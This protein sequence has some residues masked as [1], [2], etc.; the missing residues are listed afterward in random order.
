MHVLEIPK[1]TRYFR[2]HHSVCAAG[3]LSRSQT[4]HCNGVLLRRQRRKAAQ[5]PSLIA[6][7]G[8]PIAS[9]E[10]C[11]TRNAEEPKSSLEPQYGRT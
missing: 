10:L 8:F 1:R 6:Q 3:A 11:F 2:G 5:H 4:G 7:N 9:G